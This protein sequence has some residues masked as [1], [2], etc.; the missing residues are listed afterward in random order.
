MADDQ[1]SQPLVVGKMHPGGAKI[2]HNSKVGR[3]QIDL[4]FGSDV[5]TCV[6]VRSKVEGKLYAHIF[7]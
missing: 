5:S 7:S 6:L 4:P 3:L 1:C 2:R